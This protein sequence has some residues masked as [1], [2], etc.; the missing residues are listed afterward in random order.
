MVTRRLRIF[1]MSILLAALPATGSAWAAPWFAQPLPP[2]VN[3]PTT[4]VLPVRDDF[5]PQPATFGPGPTSPLLAGERIKVDVATIVGF[6]LES[7]AA[8]DY[9]WGRMSGAPAYYKT[10]SWAVDELRKAGLADA[11]LEDFQA[12]LSTPLSG[13]ARVLG[14]PSFGEGT[15]DVVL[16]SAIVGGRGPVNGVVTA[17][18]IYVGHASSAD[19]LGRDV[20]GKI[21]VIH[22][23]P[24]PGL[25][26]VPEI[27]R[28]T[29]LMKAGAMGVIE[30]LDQIGNMQSYD[31]DRHGC[32]EQLCF[33]V[34]GADGFFLENMLGKAGMAGKTVS[35]RLSATSSLRTGLKTANGIATL[36]GATDRTIII[37]AHADAF[38]VGADDNAGGLATQLA[39]ARYFTKRPRLSHTLVFV[40]SAGHHT[41]GVGL[42]DFR[43][44]HEA[45]YVS[46]ADLIINLEH[47]SNVGVVRDLVMKQ[48]DN[49]GARMVATT[50][51]F[52]K[53]VAVS[54]RA[55]FLIDLWRQGAKCFGLSIQ[56]VVDTAAPGELGAF[57]T[58]EGMAG[59][60]PD[61]AAA[62]LKNVTIPVTQMISAGPLFHTSGE[63]VD[64][65]P[66]PGLER[67][68]RFHAFM[69]QA[70]DKA[71]ASLLLG[72]PWT[73]R[74][75]CPE[76]P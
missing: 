74:A 23:L 2:P 18:L 45:D 9:L 4:P 55:P 21:A 27:G 40:V 38:F 20:K 33:T 41:E 73:P 39:L 11:H 10:V 47:L 8:G 22:S 52:P 3:D 49:Y 5:P 62:K 29:S 43:L 50:T 26:G 6:S 17:P 46:K 25:F 37:N 70:A 32:G 51:E 28:P 63:T 66:A 58:I 36:P 30:I 31:G 16:Q 61:I 68:A 54:N 65:V 12:D 42:R 48:N 60:D 19:L 24:D 7:R 71:A 76:T 67:A 44:K 64:A 15:R 72:S 75:R 56:R 53:A 34:G 13:E 69:I 14:D 59:R 35:A 57:T 1:G